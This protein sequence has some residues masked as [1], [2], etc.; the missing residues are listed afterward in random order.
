[1]KTKN[2]G[3]MQNEAETIISCNNRPSDH[4]SYVAM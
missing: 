4:L 3:K 1:M 2:N